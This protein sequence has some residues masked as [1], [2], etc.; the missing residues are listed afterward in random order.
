MNAGRLPTQV[1]TNLQAVQNNNLQLQ[2]VTESIAVDRSRKLVVER[3]LAD[4]QQEN[5]ALGN[6]PSPTATVNPETAV[7]SARQ[8]LTAAES[9]LVRLQQR[10]KPEHPDIIRL[11]R[12]IVDL[13]AKVEAENAAAPGQTTSQGPM[14]TPDELDPP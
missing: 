5:Q 7:L 1:Q 14:L 10:L 11:Q 6:Q 2:S 13:K 3:L 12:S 9:D 4:L 8:R